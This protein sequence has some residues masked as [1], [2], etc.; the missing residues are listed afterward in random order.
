MSRVDRLFEHASVATLA[1][2]ARSRAGRRELSARPFPGQDAKA[3]PRQAL[4]GGFKVY[5]DETSDRALLRAAVLAGQSISLVWCVWLAVRGSAAECEAD[6][7]FTATADSIAEEL[8]S[9]PSRVAAV[10]SALE[11]PLVARIRAHVVLRWGEL[12]ALND[13]SPWA[14]GG[15]A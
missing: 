14:R 8:R 12:Y 5:F 11:D 9:E 7:A 1:F 13:A 6:G 4:R 3:G 15:S 2:H 10:L